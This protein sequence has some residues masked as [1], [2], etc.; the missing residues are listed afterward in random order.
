MKECPDYTINSAALAKLRAKANALGSV[1]KL[2][3][4]DQ[5]KYD[6]A[7]STAI[8]A[9]QRSE[10][11]AGIPDVVRVP[12]SNCASGTWANTDAALQAAIR[13]QHRHYH[14]NAMKQDHDRKIAEKWFEAEYERL[15][16]E[17]SQHTT[18]LLKEAA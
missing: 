4:E 12:H 11:G 10:A 5:L 15:M 1:S 7:L 16:V 8:R 18:G 6:K 9:K 3:R 14:D 2:S 17:K 13:T